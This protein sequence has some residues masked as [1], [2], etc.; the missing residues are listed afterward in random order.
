MQNDSCLNHISNCCG[1]VLISLGNKQA[2][3]E[4]WDT[5]KQKR[6]AYYY[7]YFY[8]D[9]PVCPGPTT[10]NYQLPEL[11]LFTQSK[12]LVIQTLFFTLEL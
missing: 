7:Y 4:G 10:A 11:T 8:C 12:H 9:Q 1:Q 5:E 3:I 2:V 6:P